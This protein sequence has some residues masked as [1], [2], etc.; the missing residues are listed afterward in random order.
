M[1]TKQFQ[2]H[3]CVPFCSA[4]SKCNSFHSFPT[5]SDLRKQWLIN[6]RRDPYTVTAHTKVCSGHFTSDQL[7]EPTSLKGGR[8]LVK[9]AV[10]TLFEWNI[11]EG[12]TEP[13]PP[14]QVQ[15]WHSLQK[16]HNYCFIPGPPEKKRSSSSKL[17]MSISATEDQSKYVK[18]LRKNIWEQFIKQEF[19]L[20]RFAGSDEDI[21][22]YTSW[23][24]FCVE[25]CFMLDMVLHFYVLNLKQTDVN[26]IYFNKVLVA[27]L[28]YLI[29]IL[30]L[31]CQMH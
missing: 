11:C 6:I 25:K 3:C 24:S 27:E 19:C 29:E 28:E 17:D 22:F 12:K 9:G 18:N 13:P 10:P 31:S 30:Y 8:R 4:S 5:D 21:Q 23:N 7:I 2:R 16:D 15:E 1:D 26:W 20:Q 14:L